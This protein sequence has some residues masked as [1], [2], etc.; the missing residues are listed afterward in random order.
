[1]ADINDQNAIFVTDDTANAG[2][3][4]SSPSTNATID[5]GAISKTIAIDILDDSD[6][7][8]SETFSVTLTNATNATVDDGSAVGTITDND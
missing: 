1:M 7:E 3:D 4:Y 6:L 8:S 2:A 5:P